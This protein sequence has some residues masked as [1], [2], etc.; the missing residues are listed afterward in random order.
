MKCEYQNNCGFYRYLSENSLLKGAGSCG[1]ID[2]DDCP[3]SQVAVGRI[4]ISVVQRVFNIHKDILSYGLPISYE[5][6]ERAYPSEE[7]KKVDV[8]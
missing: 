6:I 8:H 1:K 7:G 3:R 2:V 4:E 5:E